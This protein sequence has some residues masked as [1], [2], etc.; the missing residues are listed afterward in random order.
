MKAGR[1]HR[2]PLS[3]RALSIQRQLEKM[4]AGEFV[5]PGQARE[6]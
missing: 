1:E 5:F 4:K 6:R 3:P 2:V